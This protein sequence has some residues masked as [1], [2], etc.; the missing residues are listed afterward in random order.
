MLTNLNRSATAQ[1]E[2]SGLEGLGTF[3]TQSGAL[4]AL[5]Y[6]HRSRFKNE[7]GLNGTNPE[8]LIAAAH[9]GCFNMAL[10]FQLNGAGYTATKLL[11]KARVYMDQDGFDYSIAKIELDLQ[12][13]VPGIELQ[14]FQALAESA[15]KGCPVSQALSSVPISLNVALID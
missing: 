5:P 3:S 6:S 8:E 15:K 9:A 11:T 2:G 10:S 14:E 13:N 4:Q 12:G 1:W 7:D